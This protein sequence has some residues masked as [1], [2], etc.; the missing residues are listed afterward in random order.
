VPVLRRSWLFA[1]I[2]VVATWVA[3]GPAL[4]GGFIWDD[5]LH[6]TRPS[7]R[8]LAGLYRIWFEVDAAFQY[9]PVLHTAFWSEHRLWG[10]ATLGYHLVNVLLHLSSCLMVARILRRLSI[11]GAI[12]AAAIFAL[13]PV[14]VESVAWMSEQKNTLSTFF[15]LASMLAYLRFEETRSVDWYLGTLGLFVC[16]LG[17]KTVTATLP[18]G[19]LVILWWQRGRLSWRRDVLPTLPLFMLGAG[20]GLMSAWWELRLN[21]ATGLG[22]ELTLAQ[23]VLAAGRAIWFHLGKLVWPSH[24]TFIYPRW[25]VDASSGWQYLFPLGLVGLAAA[26][27]AIRR[28]TR[29]PLATLLFFVGTL[30]PTLGFFNFYAIRYSLVADHFQYLASLGPIALVAAGATRVCLHPRMQKAAVPAASAL[31]LTLAVLSWR[32]SGVYRGSDQV[33]IDTLEK[34]PGCW[35]AYNNLARSYARQGRLDEAV[36][37]LDQAVRLKSDDGEV[38]NNLGVVLARQ[39]RLDEAITHFREAVR[40][41]PT[42]AKAHHNWA[43]ALAKQGKTSEAIAHHREASRI[44]Q[45]LPEARGD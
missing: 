29:A 41:Q 17:S 12:L 6:I 32:Q 10:D 16:A 44:A 33:W 2:V 8:S 15:Y 1:A 42:C 27:W 4:H 23:R 36:S 35:M 40:L 19:L 43:L 38:H 30:F 31:L 20:A 26:C 39:S 37:Y 25:E 18:G 21:H 11:P 45:E 7:L 22:F 3:Y 14:H 28:R 5:N 9:Y 34:N 24:L 13:H